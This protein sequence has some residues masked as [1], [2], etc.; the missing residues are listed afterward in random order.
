MLLYPPQH[1]P[2]KFSTEG[3]S[4]QNVFI[5]FLFLTISGRPSK[6]L[7]TTYLL[8][9]IYLWIAYFPF[10]V[11]DP[12]LPLLSGES[13]ITFNCLMVSQ[14]HILIETPHVYNIIHFLLLFCLM[15]IWLVVQSEKLRKVEG[16]LFSTPF[17]THTTCL[18]MICSL[19]E[20]IILPAIDQIKK[21]F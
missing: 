10:E 13:C 11:P 2:V 3:G 18:G 4:K 20:L 19:N 7:F 14:S 16:K 8:L 21:P 9:P 15:L 5:R 17:R 6:N 12:C 1:V